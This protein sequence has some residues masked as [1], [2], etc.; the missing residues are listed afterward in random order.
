MGL[1]TDR[2]GSTGRTHFG[3][4][5]APGHL[6]M[7][8]PAHIAGRVLSAVPDAVNATLFL[9]AW[10]APTLIGPHW[11]KTMMLVMLFEFICIHS[12]AFM[13]GI[14]E[15]KS[16]SRVQRSLAMLGLGT[17]YLGLAAAFSLIFEAW[18]PVFAFLWLLLGKIVALWSHQ[19]TT[20]HYGQF[21][22]AMS[23]GLFI[24]AVVLGAV[25]PFPALMIT[26]EVR[27]QAAI[28]GSGLW[29]DNPQRMLASGA[30]YFGA[31][32]WVKLKY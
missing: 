10:L 8:R 20:P 22:W 7:Q 11:I 2:F 9:L 3:R 18:W 16:M 1:G 4:A 31:M 29:V 6:S 19:G 25:I 32:V 15:Q 17:V 27:A 28:P 21:V 5:D 12:S 13:M 14:G 24:A 23:T 26:E 30:A